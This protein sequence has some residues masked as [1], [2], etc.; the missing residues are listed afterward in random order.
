MVT[1]NIKM[2]AETIPPPQQP[3][4]GHNWC[5]AKGNARAG[6]AHE[7]AHREVRGTRVGPEHDELAVAR[8]AR[9][10]AH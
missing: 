10:V 8:T 2:D 5:C 9:D 4:H 6:S 7:G 1:H 3:E